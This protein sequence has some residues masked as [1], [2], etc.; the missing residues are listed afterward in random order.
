[1][2]TSTMALI[3]AGLKGRRLAVLA[4]HDK[5]RWSDSKHG[6]A[7]EEPLALFGQR[8]HARGPAW[9]Y[10]APVR[11]N[12]IAKLMVFYAFD[13]S[14]LREAVFSKNH[15]SFILVQHPI[16]ICELS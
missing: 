3:V 6:F 11:Q 1:M 15:R 4:R 10:R 14:S 8:L 5:R 12:P 2:G 13:I 16:R 9:V 7:V